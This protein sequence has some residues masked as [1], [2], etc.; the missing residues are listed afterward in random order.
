MAVKTIS[1]PLWKRKQVAVFF[2]QGATGQRPVIF[3][4]HGFGANDWEDYYTQLIRH[5]V[6]RGN[7]VVYSPYKTIR[8]SFDERY[9]ILWKGFE[10][11]AKRFEDQM[12]LNRVGFVGHSFGGG[13]TPAMAYKGFVGKGW[14]QK[15]AFMY[16]MAPWYVFQISP[17]ELGQFPKN[18]TL[19]VQIFDRDEVNDHRMAIDIYRNIKLPKH[20]KHFMVLRSKAMGNC[21]IVADHATPNR[22]PSLR[23]KQYGIFLPFDVLSDLAF[24]GNSKHGDFITASQMA[25]EKE[26]YKPLEKDTD[27]VPKIAEKHYKFPWSKEMNPRL[28]FKKW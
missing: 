13:A 7:I 27:P 16:I 15:S 6:S 14:G 19:L 4:S 24:N 20:N 11:A 25:S 12:D 5:M 1:N 8:A 23:I 3:F 17:D 10:L 9:D 2:P 22:N 28:L 26:G 21:D 18:T